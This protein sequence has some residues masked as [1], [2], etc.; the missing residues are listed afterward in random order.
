MPDDFSWAKLEPVVVQ[1]AHHPA[2][3]ECFDHP[4]PL[5]IVHIEDAYVTNVNSAPTRIGPWKAGSLISNVARIELPEGKCAQFIDI[6]LRE[7]CPVAP[8]ALDSR[9]AFCEPSLL[10]GLN[11]CTLDA[12]IRNEYTRLLRPDQITALKGCLVG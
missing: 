6:S 3:A 12:A 10:F 8:K 5:R 1:R 9:I 4:G 7:I 11:G 2:I